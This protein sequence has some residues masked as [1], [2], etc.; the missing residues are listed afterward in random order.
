MILSFRKY[1]E[2]VIREVMAHDAGTDISLA[3]H[4]DLNHESN[5]SLAF[6]PVCLERRLRKASETVLAR[7]S[8]TTPPSTEP[9]N[10]LLG[11][12]Q[13]RLTAPPSE[14]GY[15]PTEVAPTIETGDE[16]ESTRAHGAFDNWL[17]ICVTQ[18]GD[19]EPPFGE[20]AALPDYDFGQFVSDLSPRGS[21]N[22]FSGPHDD[23]STSQI[24]GGSNI[25]MQPS[26]SFVPAVSNG[27]GAI[28]NNELGHSSMAIGSLGD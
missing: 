9:T 26:L 13:Q 3:P 16:T 19:M 11:S 27:R 18:S 2:N 25:T 7:L 14:S 6:T 22:I 23:Y 17:D 24:E 28:P 5:R 10:S 15:A 4:N 21:S 8:T 20:S 12:I 1:Q